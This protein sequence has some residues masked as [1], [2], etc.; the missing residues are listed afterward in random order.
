M[1]KRRY[2]TGFTLIEMLIVVGIIAIMISL[3]MPSTN[4]LIQSNR[5]TSAK[6]LVRS[7]LMQA[8][9]YAA[10]ERKYAGIRFQLDGAG[11]QY[12]ILV[13]STRIQ[14]RN[15][16]GIG[17]HHPLMT[18]YTPVD[19]AQ[20]T[21][22]P[23]GNVI[24]NYPDIDLD[25]NTEIED[26]ELKDA[27]RFCVL[28]SPSGQLVKKPA[29]CGPRIASADYPGYEILY[30]DYTTIEG[31]GIFENDQSKVPSEGLPL[32]GDIPID[33]TDLTQVKTSQTSLLLFQLKKLEEMDP[34]ERYDYI[35]GS[36][37]SKP[38]MIN[39]YTG[40]LIEEE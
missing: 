27:T 31:D 38:L 25:D 17:V 23:T 18:L 33:P 20:P 24:I 5:E 32:F 12:M 11:R 36:P 21:A 26:W 39:V 1:K 9:A 37:E 29:Q 34:V 10:K 4:S 6:N 30:S 16:Y 2:K 22:M 3:V 15:F 13:E 40:K 14:L 19:N 8:Q 35:M 7:S 28:F